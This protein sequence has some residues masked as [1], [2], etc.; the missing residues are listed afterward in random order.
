MVLFVWFA[1]LMQAFAPAG[2]QL[3][4]MQA[5]AFEAH[6]RAELEMPAPASALFGA[7]GHVV[8]YQMPKLA[9]GY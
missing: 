4:S 3:T 2:A 9:A 1:M 8:R 5:A 7:A 6:L